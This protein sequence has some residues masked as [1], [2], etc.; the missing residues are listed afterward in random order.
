MS[1]GCELLNPRGRYI[2]PK[3]LSKPARVPEAEQDSAAV[4]NPRLGTAKAKVSA[5]GKGQSTFVAVTTP[6]ESAL[7]TSEYSGFT[8]ALGPI[9]TPQTP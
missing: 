2:W 9:G 7:L 5:G 4:Y 1:N 8:Q 6:E 3:P